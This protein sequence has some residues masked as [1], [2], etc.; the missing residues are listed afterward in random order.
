MEL[1]KCSMDNCKILNDELVAT[2][3]QFD[4]LHIAHQ[5]LIEKV[6]EIAKEKKLKS[7]VITFDPHPDVILNKNTQNTSI[8][9]LNEK[10]SIIETMG[11]DYLIIIKFNKKVAEMTDSEFV[12]QF[13]L[14]INIKEIVVGLDFC[15]GKGG[16]G[17]A[18]NISSLA[19]DKIN[20]TII[21]TKTYQNEKIGTAMI[22]SML[23]NGDVLQ[24]SK[25]LGRY[26]RISGEV[27][28]GNQ[29]GS[30]INLPT[31][32][33]EI[34]N[35]EAIIKAGVYAS[36]IIIDGK[37]YYGFSNYGNNPSFNKRNNNILETNIF[38]F[39][40]DLY[41]KYI[42]IELIDYIREEKVFN[43]KDDF[44]KQIV[45]DKKMAF[46]ICEKEFK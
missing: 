3:G 14:K 40:G 26:Y 39:S 1:I 10:A 44:L 27:K 5:M 12:N 16:K 32:N 36:R 30:S 42:T 22:K 43:N 33:I 6:L 38:N 18:N 25:L 34:N 11:I 24:A 4:G 21:S 37:Y 13:L 28:K 17:K 20:T 46:A 7:A 2:I 35:N 45:K 41:G 19:N 15:F 31:A 8:M 29:I 9:T 23:L